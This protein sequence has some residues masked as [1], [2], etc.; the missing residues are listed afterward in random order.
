MICGHIQNVKKNI[1]YKIEEKLC[2][3]KKLNPKFTPKSHY[4]LELDIIVDN[5]Y[6]NIMPLVYF[7]NRFSSETYDCK[8]F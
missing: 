2:Y 6:K 3:A 1:K 5:R 4:T 7:A 8:S